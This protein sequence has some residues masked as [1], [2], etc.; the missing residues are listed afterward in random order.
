VDDD[1]HI[2]IAER[3]RHLGQRYTAARRSLIEAIVSADRPL[4]TAELKGAGGAL[5]QST[6][7]RNLAVL[8][9]AGVVRRVRGADD[10]ARFELAEELGGH[11]HHLV[12]ISCGGIEDFTP[13]SRFERSM[14]DLVARAGNASGFRVETHS[15]DLLGTCAA[16]ES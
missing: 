10:F 2:A 3:L 6:T 13:P 8:E 4:T 1:L 7:Y 9:Q 16:C 11:H 12:C 5:P 15:L 14:A